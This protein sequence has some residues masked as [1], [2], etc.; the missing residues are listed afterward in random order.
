MKGLVIAAFGL[1]ILLAIVIGVSWAAAYISC[2]ANPCEQRC[3]DNWVAG[4]FFK[5]KCREESAS[6]V[7]ES[8]VC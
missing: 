4:E 2:R 3:V 5:R 8:G 6:R 7:L 1:L